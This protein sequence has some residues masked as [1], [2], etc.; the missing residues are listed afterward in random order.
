MVMRMSTRQP[1]VRRGV[2]SIIHT[3]TIAR[4]RQSRVRELL[5]RIFMSKM[6]TGGKRKMS[7][8]RDMLRASIREL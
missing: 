2:V 8:E 3:I 6:V 7:R 1:S 4:R 5:N